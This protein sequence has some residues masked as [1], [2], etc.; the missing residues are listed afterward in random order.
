MIGLFK[1]YTYDVVFYK[2]IF[3]LCGAMLLVKSPSKYNAPSA[4]SRSLIRFVEN[5]WLSHSR[6]TPADNVATAILQKCLHDEQA[7]L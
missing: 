2:S 3:K 5:F 4:T 6:Y 1:L 7:K